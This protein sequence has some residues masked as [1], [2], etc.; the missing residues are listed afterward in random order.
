[1][2]KSNMLIAVFAVIMGTASVS[3]AQEIQF[4]GQRGSV[5]FMDAVKAV[6]SI[7]DAESIKP[8][9][10]T[11]TNSSQGF[12][13]AAVCVDGRVTDDCRCE[14]P[15][16]PGDYCVSTSSGFQ[17]WSCI[18]GEPSIGLNANDAATPKALQ[19]N[20]SLGQTAIKQLTGYYIAQD[21]LKK[22]TLMYIIS[23]NDFSSDIEKLVQNRETKILYDNNGV[24]VV[25][26][27]KLIVLS[28]RNLIE[29]ARNT[30][31][32][33]NKLT[34]VEEVGIGVAI[35]CVFSNDCWDAIGDV[36]SDVSEWAHTHEPNHPN[37]TNGVSSGH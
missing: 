27:R 1:M 31:F 20:K 11:E 10:D 5:G 28:D 19:L 32:R 33:Q 4:D 17:W 23:R 3:G 2:K 21:K 24:Y 14:I 36:V 6:D 34:G 7:H 16:F 15:L 37:D 12:G 26:G 13:C 35:G 30:R 18:V 29:S 22:A 8:V 9:P 25:N